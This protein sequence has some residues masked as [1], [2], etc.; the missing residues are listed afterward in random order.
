M[1]GSALYSPIQK[2]I[3]SVNGNL[4]GVFHYTSVEGAFGILKSGRLWMTERAHLNDRAEIEF[5]IIIAEELCRKMLKK[6]DADNF[7]KYADSVANNFRF[8]SASFSFRDP[9]FTC[10][11]HDSTHWNQYADEGRGLALGFSNRAFDFTALKSFISD[12][13]G[14]LFG[15]EAGLFFCPM[16]YGCG[17]KDIIGEILDIYIRDKF[18]DIKM[19]VTHVYWVSSMFKHENYSN[20]KEFRIFLHAKV[21]KITKSTCHAVRQRGSEM[22]SYLD[23]PI[24][25]WGTTTPT[26]PIYRICLGPATDRRV[27]S[28]LYEFYKS[29]GISMPHICRAGIS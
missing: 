1:V 14:L 21:D 6:E 17:I 23:V 13:T 4:P 16:T 29:R 20:E 26:W 9:N 10:S 8:Y 28:L 15:H 3:D 7:R 18:D 22:V 19:L 2:H 24:P 27:E 12:N 25:N 5:G 11:D